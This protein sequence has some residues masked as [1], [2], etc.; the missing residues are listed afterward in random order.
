[1]VVPV[2]MAVRSRIL[3][4]ARC[5]RTAHAR[6]AGDIQDRITVII[7]IDIRI[8]GQMAIDDASGCHLR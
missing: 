1:M 6:P 7:A 8:I 5:T 4:R 2:R 3:L